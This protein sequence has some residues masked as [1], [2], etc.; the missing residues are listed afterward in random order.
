MLA[1]KWILIL[2]NLTTIKQNLSKVSDHQDLKSIVQ[3]TSFQMS[4]RILFKLLC[5]VSL[6]EWGYWRPRHQPYPHLTLHPQR[7]ATYLRPLVLRMSM[8]ESIS[9]NQ[10]IRM[11]VSYYSIKKRFSWGRVWSFWQLLWKKNTTLV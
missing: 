4:S 2:F 6:S 5:C 10:A 9:L 7:P 3:R 1:G 11:L 8:G